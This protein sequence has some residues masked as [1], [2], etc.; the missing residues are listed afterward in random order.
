MRIATDMKFL[1]Q[2][3][4]VTGKQEYN[5]LMILSNAEKRKNIILQEIKEDQTDMYQ[6]VITV[7]SL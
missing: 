3:K 7:P 2:Q 1:E 6:G 5:E 4:V